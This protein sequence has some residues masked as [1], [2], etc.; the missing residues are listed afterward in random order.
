MNALLVSSVLGVFMAAG[1]VPA[2]RA[3]GPESIHA[4]VAP[5]G[6]DKASVARFEALL[7]TSMRGE[8]LR[9]LRVNVRATL[10]QSVAG[11]EPK[12]RLRPS[13]PAGPDVAQ[14]DPAAGRFPAT[15]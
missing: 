11:R 10:P 15:C 8:L 13:F 2:V 3:G 4:A 12:Q 7:N 5:A 1:A 9:Q 6:L 14:C